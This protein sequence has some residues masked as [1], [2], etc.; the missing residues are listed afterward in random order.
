MVCLFCRKRKIKCDMKMPCSACVKFKAECDYSEFAKNLTVSQPEE[1]KVVKPLHAPRSQDEMTVLKERLI[2]LEETVKRNAAKRR[3]QV[4]QSVPELNA[5]PDSKIT[6]N[7]PVK[8]PEP[9]YSRQLKQWGP[10]RWILLVSLDPVLYGMVRS[11]FKQNPNLSQVKTAPN[12]SVQTFAPGLLCSTPLETLA[13]LRQQIQGILPISKVVWML[14]D[15]FF[16]VVYPYLPVLDEIYIKT[17]MRKLI[18]PETSSEQPTQLSASDELDFA[19]LG[20]LLMVLRFAYL[21]IYDCNGRINVSSSVPPHSMHYLSQY[22]IS[23]EFAKLAQK[24]L[25]QYNLIDESIFD[26]VQLVGLLCLYN[27]VNPESWNSDN[28]NR[29]LSALLN[30]MA[31]CRRLNREPH[32]FAP[33]DDTSPRWNLLCRKM[34]YTFLFLDV[35]DAAFTGNC[36]NINPDTYDVT[37]PTFQPEASNVR[38]YEIEKVTLRSFEINNTMRK[39]LT[40]GLAMTGNLTGSVPIRTLTE[41]VEEIE[42]FLG[43]IHEQIR[44]ALRHDPLSEVDS[45]HRNSLLTV[46]L[47][48]QFFIFSVYTHIYYNHLKRKEYGLATSAETKLITSTMQNVIPLLP[49]LLGHVKNPFAGS[50][51]LFSISRFVDCTNNIPFLLVSLLIKYKSQYA[52]MKCNNNHGG[53]MRADPRYSNLF[54]ALEKYIAT[55]DDLMVILGNFYS[56]L[57]DRNALCKKLDY[58]HRKLHE[59]LEDVDGSAEDKAYIRTSSLFLEG[60]NQ[61]IREGIDR[62]EFTTLRQ[63]HKPLPLPNHLST[64][65]DLFDNRMFES[66]DFTAIDEL[67]DMPMLENIL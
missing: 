12:S 4:L 52:S 32:S 30:L 10:F 57:K 67:L 58:G 43:R 49:M 28:A 26:V 44:I 36:V 1:L 53:R 66:L 18:G 61:I 41:K 39:L 51:D 46:L 31:C 48:V 60:C 54:E 24:C 33:Q 2:A 17:V 25:G 20:V 7:V 35:S 16:T 63:R 64:P 34:W 42:D 9:R 29:T 47:K 13:H 11:A 21:T 14:I 55:L 22:E 65:A 40:E 6:F 3:S 38:D 19:N 45:F 8:V 15:R 56:L 62:V 27:D 5:N 59:M 37:L 50:T 23:D